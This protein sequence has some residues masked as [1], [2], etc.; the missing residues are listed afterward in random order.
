MTRFSLTS[1][2]D[3]VEQ[4]RAAAKKLRLDVALLEKNLTVLEKATKVVAAG[5]LRQGSGVKPAP[6]ARTSQTPVAPTR[7]FSA[8]RL[9]VQR[10]N[11]GLS[12]DDFGKLV[13]ASGQS[14]YKWESG[15]VRP[16]ASQLE[17]IARVRAMGRREIMEA[18]MK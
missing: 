18:L 7:R 15:T 8:A 9:A 12:A 1:L 16:R 11:L 5:V 3:Q 6:N 10:R 2:K 14:V 4:L 17:G 13:G